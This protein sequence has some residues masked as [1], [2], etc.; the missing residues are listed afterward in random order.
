[1]FNNPSAASNEHQV[2]SGC[3][4]RCVVGGSDKIRIFHVFHGI[5]WDPHLR[6]SLESC[7][8]RT[9]AEECDLITVVTSGFSP[10]LPVYA[11]VR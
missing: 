4:Y 9:S 3:F 6:G 10:M 8:K 2:N 5:S 7:V 11:H 1:M